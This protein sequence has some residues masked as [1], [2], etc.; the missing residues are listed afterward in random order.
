MFT[1]ISVLVPTRQRPERLRTMIASYEQTAA[2][3]SELVFRIDNDDQESHDLLMRHYTHRLVMGPRYDGYRST[4]QFLQ[5]ALYQ[6]TGDVVMVGNDDMLF[7]TPG[8]DRL[9]L[10][11]ANKYADGL[12]DIGVETMNASHF[13]F[14]I[15]SRKAVDALGFV[16]DPR[17]FWGDIFLRD[18]MAHFGRAVL[19]PTVCITHDWAGNRPDAVFDAAQELK[20]TVGTPEY[21]A[22]HRVF[23]QEAI[24]KLASVGA[25]K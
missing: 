15:V 2:G 18:V 8:W 17:I 24:D 3:C 23:V 7:E 16:Y 10:D 19:L 12:F 5:D 25:A 11:E 14:S 13:P 20:T 6:A 21:W 22:Q 4:P 9:I 1:K